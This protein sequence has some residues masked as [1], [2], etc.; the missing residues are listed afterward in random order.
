LLRR[1]N[2]INKKIK[3]E[4][5]RRQEQAERLKALMEKSY[6]ESCYAQHNE[7]EKAV[8]ELGD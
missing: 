2:E 5:Q 4:V 6:A 1:R 7:V 3:L 8:D